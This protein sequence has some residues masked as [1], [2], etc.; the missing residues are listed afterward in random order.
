MRQ[1]TGSILVVPTRYFVRNVTVAYGRWWHTFDGATCTTEHIFGPPLASKRKVA[2][3]TPKQLK[4]H[5]YLES[6]SE[7]VEK[8]G[9]VKSPEARRES[10][11]RLPEVPISGITSKKSVLGLRRQWLR[12]HHLPV[13]ERGEPRLIGGWLINTLRLGGSS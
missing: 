8:G 3:L 1:L 11:L 7:R 5:L 2:V 10:P 4:T 13:K 6:P 9:T 12:Y